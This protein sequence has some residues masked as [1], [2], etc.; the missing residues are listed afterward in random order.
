MQTES[1]PTV[2]ARRRLGNRSTG[3]S[4]GVLP[5]IAA[6]S[7]TSVVALLEIAPDVIG[8]AVRLGIQ[9]SRRS[10]LIEAPSALTWARQVEGLGVGADE[11]LRKELE[12]T[13][14]AIALHRH[15]YISASGHHTVTIS[16]PPSVLQLF[17]GTHDSLVQARALPAR[18]AFHAPHLALPPVDAILG[19]SNF[20]DLQVSEDALVLIG[21]SPIT[22]SGPQTVKHVLEKVIVDI[23]SS[24]V[25]L[26]AFARA[27]NNYQPVPI[28]PIGPHIS[29]PLATLRTNGLPSLASRGPPVPKPQRSGSGDIAIVGISG[30]FPGGDDLE[31]FWD[32]LSS[33]LDLHREIPSSRFDLASHFDPT[34]SS[35]NSTSVPYGCFLGHPDLFDARLFNMSPREAAQTDPMARIF[36]MT[37]HEALEMA[38]YQFDRTRATDHRR[39]GV[40][41][42]QTSDDYREVNAGQNV[43]TFW[44]PGGNRMFINGRVNYHYGWEGQSMN[45]DG[46][47]SSSHMA[48]QLACSALLSRECDTAVAGGGNLIT[49]P[50]VY[51]GLDRGGFLSHT[52]PCKPLDAQADGYCRAEAVGALVLKRLEDAIADRDNIQA[53]IKSISTNHSAEA[54]SITH[55][56]AGTQEKLL[57]KV[58]RDAGVQPGDIDYLEM[59]G[60]GTQAGDLQ[61]TTSIASVF[62][63][64]RDSS[65]PLYVGALKANV[66]HSE[67]A[68]GVSA[69]IKSILMLR[70]STI[71]RHVGI[72]TSMNPKLPDL[73]SMNIRVPMTNTPLQPRRGQQGKRRIIISNFNA[74]GGNTSLLLEDMPRT[75]AT[76]SDPRTTQIVTISA[77]TSKSLAQNLQNMVEYLESHGEARLCD[78]AYTT[79]A[80][81]MHHSLRTAHVASSTAELVASLK[82]EINRSNELNFAKVPSVMFMFTGQGSLFVGMGHQ[83][84]ATSSAFRENILASDSICCQLGFPSFVNLIKNPNVNADQYTTV[85]A[86]LAQAA[87]ELALATAWISWGVKPTAVMGH[88]LG[89]YVALCVAEVLSATDMFYLIGHRALL[90]Q[91]QCQPGTHSMLAVAMG[92]HDARQAIKDTG[93][94]LCEIA[95]L[96]GTNSTTITGPTTELKSL[97]ESL[98]QRHIKSSILDVPFAY[99]SA[100]VQDIVSEYELVARQVHYAEPKLDVVSTLLGRT[101]REHGVFN[102]QYLTRQAREPVNFLGAINECQERRI[103]DQDSLWIEI[104]PRPTCT[105]MV[106]SAVA[107]PP[108]RLISSMR[109]TEDQWQTLCKGL[110]D[111]YRS[112]VYVD[113][114]Q[115]HKEYEMSLQLLD[116]PKYAF[117]LKSHWIQYEG[118]WNRTKLSSTQ[119]S[120]VF[121]PPFSSTTLQRMESDVVSKGQRTVTFLSDLNEPNLKDT[122]KGHLVGDW[123]LCPSSVYA[124]MAYSA[125]RY[126]WKQSHPD[127]EVPAL[128]VSGMSIH[129]PIV[130][131][132]QSDQQVRI[133]AVHEEKT[134]MVRVTYGLSSGKES[135]ECTVLYE[136]SDQWVSN[137]E[138]QAYFVHS[139]A[140]RLSVQGVDNGTT[141][142]IFRKTAYRI[143]SRLVDYALPYQGMDE[144]FFDGDKLEGYAKIKLQPKPA[145]AEFGISPYWIDSLG[146]LSG[147]V[148]NA[149]SDRTQVYISEGFESMRLLT[150]LS[151]SNTYHSYVRMVPTGKPGWVAGNVYILQGSKIVGVIQG[152]KFRAMKKKILEMVMGSQPAKSA[153]APSTKALQPIQQV[154]AL[155]VQAL[156][157]DF[158]AP[159]APA[160][161][162]VALVDACVCSETGVDKTEI[163]DETHLADLGIDSLLTLSLLATLREQADLSIPASDFMAFDTMGD[164]RQYV[165]R[166]TFTPA[167][168]GVN[169]PAFIPPHTAI[170]ST[171]PSVQVPAQGLAISLGVDEAP[172]ALQNIIASELGLGGDEIRADEYL[173]EFG[174]DSLMTMAVLHAFKEKTGTDL[175][176]SFFFEHPTLASA[177]KALGSSPTLPAHVP[178]AS[179]GPT[180]TPAHRAT[181]VELQN[182]SSSTAT[183]K[184][185]LFLLPDGSGSAGSYLNLKLEPDI[186]V[187]ALNSPFL[188]D[189]DAFPSEL[190]SVV[191]LFVD[192]ILTQ[193]PSG[194][195][196]LGGWSMGA[197]YAYEA[198]NLLAAMGKR[199][200]GIAMIDPCP[201]N[202]RPMTAQTIAVLE[203]VGVFAELGQITAARQAIVRRHFEASTSALASYKPGPRHA[204]FEVLVVTARDG[205]LQRLGKRD[206]EEIWDRYRTK[207]G[208]D[209]AWLFLVREGDRTHGWAGMFDSVVQAE[210]GGDHFSIM[211][212]E[213]IHE[214]DRALGNFCTA[215]C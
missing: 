100:Q 212:L 34:C 93:T 89:E 196:F 82:M 102:A 53:I 126:I 64:S 165:R 21:S 172:D 24:P 43:D 91:K 66:G 67:S 97:H 45:V 205:V 57:R 194:E 215:R 114:N 19:K 125:A 54:R 83:L 87:L 94:D 148:M 60:T 128:N 183:A 56:H 204:N 109:P 74:A 199:I 48:I 65:N 133:T 121:E 31:S 52:G 47:C 146:H 138:E 18:A 164:L 5:A 151:E 132:D 46:A 32:V 175:P 197:A 50:D 119:V 113:W 173:E 107:V 188:R 155:P 9:A 73:K 163:T 177:K 206:A 2:S 111:A 104:G 106:R 157:A 16:G 77:R 210:I 6:A 209:E 150:P 208:E 105:T 39:I 36:L 80:R 58:L 103:A 181:S 99:H 4:T 7:A 69:V 30:R 84:F 14:A 198:A 17:L 187:V 71:P 85:Q 96:N 55:P 27:L 200:K 139:V 98:R 79:T 207:Y 1:G 120:K 129:S 72:K 41:F 137:W 166:V 88:S 176:A 40:Y 145:G 140:D 68:S 193:Q 42:G 25:D 143:F 174:L 201:L 23:L 161:D 179:F 86:Q 131:R 59:H 12:R 122:V 214:L 110:A 195:Y 134:N 70:K 130:L 190:Y 117:D 61:E 159:S 116:L 192:E 154:D 26:D 10:R 186:R 44:V 20:L 170:L 160:E 118:D 158:F 11:G 142:R 81:R 123:A 13:N 8:I 15:L 202:R 95:C 124:D 185:T 33:G 62:G 112:G 149:S 191:Q 3:I 184:T 171:A 92:E 51:A 213:Q 115:F 211:K 49:N 168:T 162:I 169:T 156:P 147:F 178:T 153:N 90:M 108:S 76:D 182:G 22:S 75:I 144:V 141:E 38:G 35:K 136:D 37:V 101:V 29:N 135:A 167:A 189:P 152:V 127:R 63:N 28:G 203:Q 78:V 180:P